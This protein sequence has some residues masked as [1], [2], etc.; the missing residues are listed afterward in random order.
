MNKREKMGSAWRRFGVVEV[1]AKMLYLNTA[2]RGYP[3]GLR[4]GSDPRKPLLVVPDHFDSFTI[5][6]VPCAL[7]AIQVS[8]S[9]HLNILYILHSADVGTEERTTLL[10][11]N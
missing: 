1:A 7:E 3:K 5:Q 11:E 10:L 6:G 8:C 4:A 9:L 2:I